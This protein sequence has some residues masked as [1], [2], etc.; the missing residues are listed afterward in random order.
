MKRA[1]VLIFCFFVAIGVGYAGVV[2]FEDLGILPGT[3]LNAFSPVVTGGFVYGIGPLNEFQDLHIG[4]QNFFPYNGTTVGVTHDD[5]VLT[6]VGG[7][8]FSLQSFDFA[9]WPINNEMPF[10]VTGTFFGGGT[11]VKNFSPDGLV[12]GPGGVQD[13]QTFG[14]SSEWTNLVQVYWVHTGAGTVQ[15]LFGLD[16]I[17]VDSSSASVPEPTSLLLLGIGL[18]G[19][20][21]AGWRRRK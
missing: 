19:L 16:N 8:T 5:A 1:L 9:G 18:G 11:I 20:A 12:D 2:T 21:L 4:S 15:G 17:V 13:F 6:K 14:L 10:T 7:G 3:Q